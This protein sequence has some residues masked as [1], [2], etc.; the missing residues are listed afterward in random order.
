MR[1]VPF[2]WE[3]VTHPAAVTAAP[4]LPLVL[5]VVPVEALIE[6]LIKVLL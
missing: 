1:V 5:T 3:T 6:Q 4:L 2:G